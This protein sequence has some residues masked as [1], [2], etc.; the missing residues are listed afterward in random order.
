[1]AY[2]LK[3]EPTTEK[4]NF[5]PEALPEDFSKKYFL[6]LTDNCLVATSKNLFKQNFVLESA[7]QQARQES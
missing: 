6:E 4:P 5:T 1:M 2:K 3:K 7:E